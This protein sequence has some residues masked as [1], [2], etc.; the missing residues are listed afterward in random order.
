MEKFQY[1]LSPMEDFTDNA[2]RTLCYNHGADMTFT[3][4]LRIE[5]L[6]DNVEKTW[7]RIEKKDNTPVIIQLLGSSEKD[8]EKFLNMFKPFE[9]FR[10]FN[11]NLGCPAPQV[12]SLGY[13][14]A[15]VKKVS[16]VKNLVNMIK[17]KGY[18][19]SIKMRLG[20]NIYDK[21]KKVYLNLIKEV[22]AD[23]F[24]IHARHG[25]ENYDK[26]SDYSIFEE[27]CNTGKMIIANGDI[28]SKEKVEILKSSGVK[29]VM[30]GR[31]AI[32]NPQI[33]NFLKGNKLISSEE[34]KK[35]YNELAEKYD[36][37]FR[38]RKNIMKRILSIL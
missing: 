7:S 33:F 31:S 26:K 15:M 21:Q 30:I 17:R 3:E 5:A 9:G 11:L 27:C 20:K 14:C 25:R 13:G 22:D 18:S 28:D 24:I 6:A 38:Y 34:I 12:V 29:G 32:N 8:L 2:F 35:E 23:F 36:A 19:C 4:L 1:M 16:I 37:P 10:G